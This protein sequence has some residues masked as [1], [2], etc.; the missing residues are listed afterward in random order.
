MEIF[1]SLASIPEGVAKRLSEHLNRVTNQP[2]SNNMLLSTALLSALVLSGPVGDTCSSSQASASTHEHKSIVE[3]AL[4]NDSFSTLVT[5]LKAADLVGALSGEG[6]FTVLA[7]T[8]EAFA[9]LPAEQLANLLKPENKGLLQAILT[10]HVL[11]GNLPAK[12][13]LQSKNAPT[14]NGQRVDIK[15]NDAGVMVDGAKVIKTDITCSNG[16]IH[17][18]DSII[19]PSTMNIVETAIDAG[20]FKTL[21]AA[22]TAAQLVETLQGKGPF[23]VFA[24][25]DEAFASLP[26]GTVEE[27]LLPKNREKLAAILKFHVVPG[28]IYSES[29]AAGTELKTV[30][31]QSVKTR[32]VDSNVFV[33]GA[34]I[35][36]A[37]IESTNGVIHIIDSV[38][39]P[40]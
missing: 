18:I 26:K 38:L 10:Y 2:P 8:N 12:V 24:P 1:G 21:A 4:A 30:Y 39:L 37:D 6:P 35:V 36:T 27:L 28:R 13:V 7:P 34:R 33:N 23:T 9:K 25:T 5:A 40:E 15:V 32:T 20:S 11:P 31:G 3:T 29:V 19:L 22:L 14:L 17:V 16:V